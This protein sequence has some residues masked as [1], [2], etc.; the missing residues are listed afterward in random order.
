[1][2]GSVVLPGFFPVEPLDEIVIFCRMHLCLV[3]LLVVGFATPVIS[4]SFRTPSVFVAQRGF[5]L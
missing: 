1:M 5:L 4:V 3:L 2:K